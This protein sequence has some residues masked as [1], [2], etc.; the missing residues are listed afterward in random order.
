MRLPSL[1]RRP[2]QKPSGQQLKTE[3]SVKRRKSHPEIGSN[4]QLPGGYSEYPSGNFGY[5]QGGITPQTNRMNQAN[6]GF[7]PDGIRTH[8]DNKQTNRTNQ[9][10]AGFLPDGIR[11]HQ[12]SNLYG[13]SSESANRQSNQRYGNSRSGNREGYSSNGTA[14]PEHTIMQPTVSPGQQQEVTYTR[15]GRTARQ[16]YGQRYGENLESSLK[17]QNSRLTSV[18]GNQANAHEKVLKGKELQEAIKEILNDPAKM[19]EIDRA[20]VEGLNKEE[21]EAKSKCWCHDHPYQPCPY[22]QNESAFGLAKEGWELY[23]SLHEHTMN[24]GLA[25]AGASK[26]RRQE[27]LNSSPMRWPHVS[28]ERV[29]GL[30]KVN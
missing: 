9:A 29:L 28:R 14:W 13:K 12:G 8:Q 6:A 21:A 4:G 11:T 30:S 22:T 23:K 18:S 24:E 27:K 2:K 7:L 15:G 1:R 3:A 16:G 25:T 17:P 26:E 19:G 5:G 20:V 10:N